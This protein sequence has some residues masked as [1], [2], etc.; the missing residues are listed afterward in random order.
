MPSVIPNPQQ[1]TLRFR[2][3]KTTILLLVPPHDSL[4]SV[5]TKLLEAIKATGATEVHGQTLPTNPDD[6]LLGVP[7][8]MNEPGEGWTGLEFPEIEEDTRKKGP[9]KSGVHNASP[10][11]AGLKDGS[12]LAF[13]FRT[14]ASDADDLDMNTNEWDVVMPS[15]DDEESS[16]MKESDE[17]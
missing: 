14:V 17:L 11:G 7:V 5:K 1:F 15:F 4:T 10:S 12:L 8:N 9:K 2:C 3:H 6:V 13:K 16:Q